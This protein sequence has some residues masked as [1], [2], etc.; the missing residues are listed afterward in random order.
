MTSGIGKKLEASDFKNIKNKVDSVFGNGG[1]NFGYGQIASSNIASIDQEITAHDW[2]LL[3]NDM[4]KAKK[5]QSGIDIGN[6]LDMDGYNLFTITSGGLITN[7]IRN[8]YDIFANTLIQNRLN[9]VPSQM[10]TSILVNGHRSLPWVNTTISH[11]STITGGDIIDQSQDNI[12]YFFNSGGSLKISAARI[13]GDNTLKNNKW[14]EFLTNIGNI[15]FNYLSTSSTGSIG[16][17]SNVGFYDLTTVN[18][19]I[20]TAMANGYN[21]HN[22][23][24]VQIYAKVAMNSAQIILSVLYIDIDTSSDFLNV[25]SGDLYSMIQQVYASSE[26]AL[27]NKLTASDIGLNI[28]VDFPIRYKISSDIPVANEGGTAIF[29]VIASANIN[30]TLFWA[31]TGTV[32]NLDFID[33]VTTGIVN[34]PNSNTAQITRTLALDK[35][36]ETLESF[37]IELHSESSSGPLLA[38]SNSVSIN[39]ISKFSMTVSSVSITQNYTLLYNIVSTNAAIGTKLYVTIDGISNAAY[40][41][42]SSVI[43]NTTKLSLGLIQFTTSAFSGSILFNTVAIPLS[44]NKYDFYLQFRYNSPT[45][46]IA[47]QSPLM[48]YGSLGIIAFGTATITTSNFNQY[49]DIPDQYNLTI[50]EN[51]SEIQIDMQG[52]VGGN[53]WNVIGGTQNRSIGDRIY[54]KILVHT[55]DNILLSIGN[56]GSDGLLTVGG[57]GGKSNFGANGGSGGNCLDTISNTPI[58]GG[59]GG[60]AATAILINAQYIAVAGGGGGGTGGAHGNYIA[61]VDYINRPNGMIGSNGET[62]S[63]GSSSYGGSGGGGGGGYPLGGMGGK[64]IHTSSNFGTG[65]TKGLSLVPTTCSTANAALT[66]G[67]ASISWVQIQRTFVNQLPTALDP[68]RHYSFAIK[69]PLAPDGTTLLYS[70]VGN[71][72]VSD[73]LGGV[74]RLIPITINGT[75]GTSIITVISNRSIYFAIQVIQPIG[76]VVLATST[77][78]NLT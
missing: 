60:G 77:T 74:I 15:I 68:T 45:G 48:H 37:A 55:G 47:L 31:T 6:L 13:N 64:F 63:L 53:S 9:T 44:A 57:E 5:H 8:Q 33:N 71:I 11:I 58:R 12:R 4:A 7:D 3:R 70:L 67:C 38:T 29:N 39:D 52:G 22:T 10:S 24:S 36:T 78:I 32:N 18:T 62:G 61:L 41:Q 49:Y 14:S 69:V 30:G 40:V 51:V 43:Q 20:Y 35:V 73:V 65:G 75:I 56:N 28:P 25:I 27:V 19:L 21:I 34:F 16:A 2:Q 42:G 50:P 46:P 76:S 59:G 17:S 66:K 1:G 72:L 26:N 23:M 54:G